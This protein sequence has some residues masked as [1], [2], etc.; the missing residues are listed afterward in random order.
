MRQ[1]AGVDVVMGR[2]SMIAK[3]EGLQAV[4]TQH[5]LLALVMGEGGGK[6]VL[7]ELGVERRD[8]VQA[9]T[10]VFKRIPDL[11]EI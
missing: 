1:T 11:R 9:Y 6:L 5:V 10:K 4:R 3:R 7:G 8:M 2:A